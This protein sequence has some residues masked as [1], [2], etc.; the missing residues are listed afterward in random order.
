M[1]C[2]AHVCYTPIVSPALPLWP[3]VSPSRAR[4][5][6]VV[7]SLVAIAMSVGLAV[8]V[9]TVAVAAR[10]LSLSPL[11]IVMLN[12]LLVQ[13][14]CFG[15]ITLVYWLLRG[16]PGAIGVRWPGRGDLMTV[17]IATMVAIAG[18]TIAGI[19]VYELGLEPASNQIMVIGAEEPTLLLWLIPAA[20]LLIG[21]GE[22]LLFRGFAQ[23]RLREVFG[24]VTSIAIAG[25][26]FALVHAFALTDGWTARAVSVAVLFIPSVVFGIAYERTN[27]IV[28]PAL[29]HASYDAILLW[30]AYTVTVHA[31]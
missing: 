29:I 19:V 5:L 26:L 22:E 24:P 13:G 28:V 1:R 30:V 21:P 31:A 12:L 11:Q 9:A 15:G 2:D 25:A 17:L 10:G 6:L 16:A 20:F 27:N 3:P 7:V 23:R 8:L 14:L 18:V 4:A